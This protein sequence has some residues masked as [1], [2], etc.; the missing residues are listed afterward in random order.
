MYCSYH[1]STGAR[2]Q[3]SSCGRPLC[4]A[5]DHRIKGYPY[6]QDCI[7]LGVER[8]HRV[9]D[10]G[11]SKRLDRVSALSAL[12]PEW[13]AVYNGQNIKPVFHF[14]SIVGLFEMASLKVTPGVFALGGIVYYLYS[15]VAA[16]RTA[17]LIS[18]G[19]S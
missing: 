13:G 11:R 5:C 4:H 14:V 18:R 17:A 1:T 3:C 12:R 2:V 10:E 8:L 19:E 7:V 6:C 16:Y 15:I 9:S